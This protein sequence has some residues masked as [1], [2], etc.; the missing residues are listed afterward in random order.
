MVRD[1]WRP[2]S[3]ERLELKESLSLLRRRWFGEFANGVRQNRN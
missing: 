2:Y 3:P 1:E